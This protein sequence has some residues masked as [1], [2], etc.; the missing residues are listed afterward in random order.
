ME[1][2]LTIIFYITAIV[3]VIL[4]ICKVWVVNDDILNKLLYSDGLIMLGIII[5]RGVRSEFGI[6]DEED[7]ESEYLHP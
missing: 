4:F 6:G 5:L 3:A 1:K 7:E 2:I